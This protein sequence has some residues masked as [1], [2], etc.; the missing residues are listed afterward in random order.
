MCSWWREAGLAFDRKTKHARTMRLRHAT[1]SFPLSL[2]PFPLRKARPN[3]LAK[4]RF[5]I[6][7]PGHAIDTSG[8]FC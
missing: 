8:F 6:L 1:E 3:A 7:V 5:F 2:S 4:G